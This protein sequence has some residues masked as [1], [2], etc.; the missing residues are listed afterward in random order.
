MQWAVSEK[1]LMN[2][3]FQ[4]RQK[5]ISRCFRDIVISLKFGPDFQDTLYINVGMNTA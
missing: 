4:V 3:L 2:V 1:N 5:H